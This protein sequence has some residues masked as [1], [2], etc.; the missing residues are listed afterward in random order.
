MVTGVQ[1]LQWESEKLKVNKEHSRT[2]CQRSP[3]SRWKKIPERVTALKQGL[4]KQ[5]SNKKMSLISSE[6][7]KEL[8]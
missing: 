2:S 7:R 8:R 5:T 1:L 4:I 6:I 3:E